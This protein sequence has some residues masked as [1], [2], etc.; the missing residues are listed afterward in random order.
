MS[1]FYNYNDNLR[2]KKMIYQKQKYLDTIIKNLA[3]TSSI[4]DDTKTN[5]SNFNNNDDSNI[6]ISDNQDIF[7]NDNSNINNAKHNNK[8]IFTNDDFNINISD[9]HDEIDNENND[10]LF[11]LKEKYMNLNIKK[12][13]TNNLYVSIDLK[14]NIPE[15]PN[16]DYPSYS[17]NEINDFYSKRLND[18]NL[19]IY[20]FVISYNES[21]IL[22]HL[23]KHYHYVTKIF[24][25]DNCSN[26]NTVD[27]ALKD[28]RCEIIYFSSKFTDDIN[29]EIKNNCW[30]KYRSECD[31]CIVC[32]SDEFLFHSKDIY[33]LL[34]L[35]KKKHILYSY[36]GIIG[37]NM[38][39]DSTVYDES[40]FLYEQITK[41][42]LNKMYD[43]NIIFCPLLIN[44]INYTPGSHHCYPKGFSN[45]Y[46][47]GPKS[48]LLH[49][50]FIGGLDRLK[51]RQIDY[52]NRMSKNN[53]MKSQGIHYF[54]KD[55]IECQ[56]NEAL[57]RSVK[58]FDI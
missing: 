57:Q 43:K 34:E 35:N 54:D 17:I 32:D 21:F 56:Y 15:I 55:N 45:K 2:R 42:Y 27:I 41:G 33:K 49:F 26:D 48:I 16:L 29:Q 6:A 9:N 12:I 7:T 58:I 28:P 10:Y 53:I 3:Y 1:S 46:I 18:D 44:E 20:L 22:P 36:M 38:V 8:N 14:D 24:I 37:I 13:L 23:L 31:Y 40:I 25:Y 52:S 39:S 4:T 11:S 50:K 47:I 30:K 5:I 19:I 51:L